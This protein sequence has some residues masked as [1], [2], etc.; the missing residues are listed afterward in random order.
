MFVCMK[1]AIKDQVKDIRFTKRLKNHPVCLST[2]GNVSIEM[3]KVINA[4]PTDEKVKAETILEIN[5]SH[6]IVDKLKNLYETD[7]DALEKYLINFQ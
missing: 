5:E 4:M 1:D 6:P 3:E 7:K 2:E